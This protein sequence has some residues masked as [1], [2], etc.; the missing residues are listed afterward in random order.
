MF[1]NGDRG[2]TQNFAADVV[3]IMVWPGEPS[4]ENDQIS[5]NANFLKMDI[6][7]SFRNHNFPGV[8]AP[9]GASRHEGAFQDL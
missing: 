1:E 4:L 2:S 3:S 7:I 8:E 5:R 6:S 9:Q